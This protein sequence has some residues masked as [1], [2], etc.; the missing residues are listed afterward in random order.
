MSVQR[1]DLLPHDAMRAAEIFAITDIGKG[2]IFDLLM[3]GAIG[4]VCSAAIASPAGFLVGAGGFVAS[5]VQKASKARSRGREIIQ[6]SDADLTASLADNDR[7]ILTTLIN[8]C[9]QLQESLES[10]PTATELCAN[11]ETLQ[12][13]PIPQPVANSSVLSKHPQLQN[14][15]LGNVAHTL[16][17]QLKPTIISAR[18]RV[19]KGIFFSYLS[20]Y[21]KQLHGASVWM[22]QPKP[23]VS[24]LGY[25]KHVDRFLG[26]NLEDYPKDCPEVAA[27][28]TQFFQAWR[29]QTHRPTLLGIDEL[30]KLQAMQPKWTKDF[31]IPQM[32]VE[33]SSGETAQRYLYIITQ[34]PLVS[35]LGM[36]GGNRSAFDFM[37]IET[38]ATLEHTESVKK[39]IATLKSIPE[40]EDYAVSPVGC[41][42]FHSGFARW[43]A[44]PEY[45]VPTI[46]P[47][48]QLCPELQALT[49]TSPSGEFVVVT[50]GPDWEPMDVPVIPAAPSTAPLSDRDTVTAFF[51]QRNLQKPYSAGQ[52]KALYRLCEHLETVELETILY[53]LSEPNGEQTSLLSRID[54]KGRSK[55]RKYYLDSDEDA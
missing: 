29:D 39:S 48:D 21:A 28:M 23:A 17:K 14:I 26:I 5:L 7:A 10:T 18:P 32:L 38:A 25:W 37:T 46:G 3:Y 54:P 12:Q 43:A 19:G 35:D 52:L 44:I 53:D 20:Q 4:L 45:P 11:P 41:L 8:A 33:G 30:V 24:E 55:V 22:L 51:I 9:P 34:S 2:T 50:A 47:D 40:A 42:V 1:G 13:G 6:M 16:A 49:K 27:Q 15:P 31:L 36:S